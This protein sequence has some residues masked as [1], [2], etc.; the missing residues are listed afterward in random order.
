M[1][2]ELK[3]LSHGSSK[4]LNALSLRTIVE[5]PTAVG[6]GRKGGMKSL[7]LVRYYCNYSNPHY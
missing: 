5:F 7:N 6:W 2:I 3:Q 4:K 1:G